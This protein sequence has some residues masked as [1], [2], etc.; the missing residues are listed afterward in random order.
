M[1]NNGIYVPYIC[2]NDAADINDY[3]IN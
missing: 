1:T 2:S 3:L